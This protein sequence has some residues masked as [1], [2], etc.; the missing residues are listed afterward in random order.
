MPAFVHVNIDGKDKSFTFSCD[1]R[2]ED[3]TKELRTALGVTGG[4]ISSSA[5]ANCFD[6]SFFAENKHYYFKMF[7]KPGFFSWFRR[8]FVGEAADS[9]TREGKRKF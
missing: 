8:L 3:D 6:L 9:R 7:E 1:V 2:I 4:F 5:D